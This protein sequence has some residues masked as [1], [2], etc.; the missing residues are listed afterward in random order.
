MWIAYLI[1]KHDYHLVVEDGLGYL[2]HGPTKEIAEANVW[3][4]FA[5]SFVGVETPAD[6]AEIEEC[7]A[8]YVLHSTELK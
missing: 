5:D 3:E 7:K 2:A 8:D 4:Q 6:R 1:S